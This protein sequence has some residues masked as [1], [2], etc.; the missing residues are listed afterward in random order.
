MSAEVGGFRIASAGT[1][2][3]NIHCSVLVYNADGP[4]LN[5]ANR[6]GC[7]SCGDE[8]FPVRFGIGVDEVTR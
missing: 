8:G 2:C 7:P 1:A 5:G 6:N 3:D 4:R